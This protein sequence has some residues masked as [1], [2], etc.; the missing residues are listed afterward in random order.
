VSGPAEIR[1]AVAERRD[2]GVDVVKVMASGGMLTIGS[3]VLGV[4]FSPEDL[5]TVVD[6]AHESGLAV[7]A[8]SHSLAGIE[9]ALAAGVDGIEHFTGL[10]DGGLEVPDATL[11]RAAA[12]G[13]VVDPTL[14]FD[15]DVWDQMPAPPPQIQ[16]AMRRTGLTVETLQA[17]RVEVVRRMRDHDVRVVSGVDSGAAPTKPHGAIALALRDLVAAGYPMAEALATAT[18]LAAEACGLAEVTGALRAG[19][20]ADLLVV[21]GDLRDGPDA[22]GVPVAV[23]V[24]GVAVE[25]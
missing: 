8:H 19:L 18:G 12:A 13:V 21:E 11:G 25:L 2:R 22:L 20:A 16:E 7:L 14:G 17:A 10:V 23:L 6:V 1:A 15:W 9:H 5:R 24:R 3:D 4:Q